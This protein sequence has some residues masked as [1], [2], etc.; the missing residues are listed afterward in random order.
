VEVEA[1]QLAERKI[2]TTDSSWAKIMEFIRINK[3]E[4]L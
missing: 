3:I 1:D 2:I 4:I